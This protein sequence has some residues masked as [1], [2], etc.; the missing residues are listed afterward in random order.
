MHFPEFQGSGLPWSEFPQ[1]FHLG[2]IPLNR[3]NSIRAAEILIYEVSRDKL[4]K[5]ELQMDELSSK[6]DV[7]E[8]FS[9]VMQR[10]FN[11]QPA[12]EGVQHRYKIRIN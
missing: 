1:T 3:T 7:G 8:A 6:T 2:G 5:R 11:L 9:A 10:G 4:L 12:S